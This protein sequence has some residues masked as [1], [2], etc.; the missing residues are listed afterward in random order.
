MS[1]TAPNHARLGAL[2]RPNPA[3]DTGDVTIRVAEMSGVQGALAVGGHC[4]RLDFEGDAPFPH[5][6]DGRMHFLDFEH[7]L[8]VGSLVLED[9]WLIESELVVTNGEEGEFV[10]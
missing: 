1:Q 8:G 3:G 5:R 9:Q 4:P 10:A 6:R 2:L 7:D